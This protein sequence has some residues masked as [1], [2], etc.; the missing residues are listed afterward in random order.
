[1]PELGKMNISY[2]GGVDIRRQSFARKIK[3]IRG[4]HYRWKVPFYKNNKM[5][6]CESR[7]ERNFVRLLDFDREAILVESQPVCLLYSYKGRK[8]KYYPDFKVITK[9][10]KIWII[11]VK[12]KKMTQ[13]PANL[14]KFI[15][16]RLYCESNG[17]EYHI[18]TEDQ[19]YQ[20]Y[21]QNNLDILRGLGHEQT[22]FNDLVYVLHILRNT[23]TSTIEMLQSNCSKLDESIFYKC[24]YKLIYYQKIYVDLINTELNEHTLVQ[25]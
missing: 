1:M 22:E 3:P 24:I 10:G 14:I 19:I 5:V 16:G 20:G 8:R 11:E 9:E 21:L 2:K 6:H 15:I 12:P 13:K 25:L 17:W 7:L 23:G 4:R 18:V